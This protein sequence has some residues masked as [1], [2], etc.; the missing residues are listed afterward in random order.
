[1]L[2]GG[3]GVVDGFRKAGVALELTMEGKLKR[4]LSW[5]LNTWLLL[6]LLPLVLVVLADALLASH[7]PFGYL[8]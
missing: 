7:P 6:L 3:G 5:V 4:Q 1:L 2:S 8:E